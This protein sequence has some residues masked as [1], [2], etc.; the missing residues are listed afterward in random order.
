MPQ[1]NVPAEWWRE[2]CE[3]ISHPLACVGL[4]SHFVWVNPAFEQLV[5]YSTSELQNMTWMKITIDEDVGGDLASVQD[6]I[7]GR[8]EQYSI[9]KRYRHKFG[10]TI[11]IQLGVWRFPRHASEQLICFI[12]QAQPEV[13]TTDELQRVQ[14][15]LRSAMAQLQKRVTRMEDKPHSPSV[16]IGDSVG[17]DK[18]GRNKTQNSNTAI[19]VVASVLAAAMLALISAVV[20]IAYYV[21]NQDS[22]V[23]PPP[24][25]LPGSNLSIE[26]PI[27]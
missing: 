16:H 9:A 21:T 19:Y 11:P 14:K 23:V 26:A 22:A 17:Q 2:A 10:K 8:S 6:V 5:G 3:V 1:D 18:T 20:W 4:D 27:D 15:Q 7:E 24:Q 12:V 25:K 13:V